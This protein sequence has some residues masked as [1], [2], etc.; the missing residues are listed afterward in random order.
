M[1]LFLTMGMVCGGG[2]VIPAL[3]LT[4]SIEVGLFLIDGS[5]ASGCSSL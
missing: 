5:I 4:Q 2:R 3:F 1:A